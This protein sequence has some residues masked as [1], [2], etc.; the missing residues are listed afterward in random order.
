MYIWHNL[1]MSEYVFDEQSSKRPTFDLDEEVAIKSN[2]LFSEIET[3]L[4]VY[5]AEKDETG[6]LSASLGEDIAVEASAW[7]GLKNVENSY[8]KQKENMFRMV[9]KDYLEEMSMRYK[10]FDTEDFLFRLADSLGIDENQCS[11][12]QIYQQETNDICELFAG[13]EDDDAEATYRQKIEYAAMLYTRHESEDVANKMVGMMDYL[14]PQSEAV[15]DR[16]AI[17]VFIINAAENGKNASREYM[18]DVIVT[19]YYY[20]ESVRKEIVDVIHNLLGYDDRNIQ[21]VESVM[22][23]GLA[24]AVLDWEMT[25]ADDIQQKFLL[26]RRLRVETEAGQMMDKATEELLFTKDEMATV[27]ELVTHI[28]SQ[29]YEAFG[30]FDED[31]I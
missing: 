6:V 16:M 22:R 30:H 19:D 3:A 9:G 5:A 29:A 18:Y 12:E 2:Q 7:L 28:H 13:K 4:K 25:H 23:T 24:L 17:D 1:K 10:N 20:D 8:N 21:L 11:L 31:C 27:M 14:C 15:A 26:E